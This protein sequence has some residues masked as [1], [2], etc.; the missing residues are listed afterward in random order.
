[1]KL[2]PWLLNRPHKVSLQTVLVCSFV[3]QIAVAV[4]LTGY[5]AYR[6]GQ[7]AVDDLA[8][9]LMQEV[10]DRIQ[11]HLYSLTKSSQDI[12][13]VVADDVEMG[14]LDLSLADL[15]PL[16]SY[17]LKRIK[18][19]DA[20]S[21]IYVGTE[22]GKFIGAGPDRSDEGDAY[23][24][25]VA[26]ETTHGNYVSYRVN[27]RG[28]RLQQ[29]QTTPQYDPRQ[30]PW[31]QAA[32]AKGNATWS[33]IYPFIGAANTGLTITAVKPFHN[34][35]GQVAGV[36]AVALYLN[37]LNDFLKRLSLTRT[38][39]V[40]ILEPSGLLVASSENQRPYVLR[41]GKPQRL[42]A[43]ASSDPL[44]R[45]TTQQ[46]SQRF[47]SAALSQHQ[48]FDFTWQG[49]RQYVQITPWRDEFGLDWQIVAV[50]PESDFMEQ[51]HQ[52]WRTSI[53][54]C[55][56]SLLVASVV[57]VQTAR[58]LTEPILR[59]NQAAKEV[60]KGNFDRV[61]QVDRADEVGELAQSFNDMAWQLKTSFSAYE[62][63]ETRFAKLLESLPVGVSAIDQQGKVIYINLEGVKLLGKGLVEDR[64]IEPRSQ[65]YGAHSFGA[66]LF[67]PN[68]LYPTVEF[69]AVRALQ[70]E[71][72]KINHL[73]IHKDTG[74]I[75]PIEVQST[76]VYDANGEIIYAISVFQDITNRKQAEQILA[77]YNWTLATQ[78]AVR[79]AELVA[80]NTALEQEVA[81]RERTQVALKQSETKLNDILNSATAAI[82][83]FRYQ[84]EAIYRSGQTVF[85]PHVDYTFCSAGHLAVFGYP[86]E[87]FMRDRTL[88]RSRIPD[89]DWEQVI[90]PGYQLLFGQGALVQGTLTIEYRFYDKDGS[91][92]WISDSLVARW[93]ESDRSWSITAVGTDIT[94]RK[95]AEEALQ[96]SE[97]NLRVVFN[98]SYDAMIIHR[99]DGT[100]LDVNDRM[101]ELYQVTRDEAMHLSF[102][103]DYSAPQ[104]PIDQLPKI[105]Q[106]VLSGETICHEWKAKRP[107]DGF[108]FDVEVALR[109]IRLAEQ[110]VILA[111]VR[112]I[113]DR[114][115]A[116]AALEAQRAFLY[117]V[118]DAVPNA[119]FVKDRLGRYTTINQAFAQRY[120][121]PVEVILGKRDQDFNPDPSQITQFSQ[122]NR[123]VMRS[124]QPYMTST[125][126]RDREGEIRWYQAVISPF[127]DAK[128]KVQGVI[129]AATDITS[130]KQIEAELRQ[131]KEEAEAANKAKSAFLANISHELR[132][133]L[134]AILGFSQLMAHDTLTFQQQKQ[135]AT[136]NRNGEHL[137][138]LINDVLSLAK[139]ESGHIGL[140]ETNCNLYQLLRAIEE[141]FSLRAANKGIQLICDRA[142]VP[143]YLYTDEQ[144]LRQ[145]LANLVDNAIKFT[146]QGSVTVRVR[147][148]QAGETHSSRRTADNPIAFLQLQVEDTGL[149][150]A[151]AD[152]ETIFESFKQSETGRRSHQGSGLGL[153]ICRHYVQ[154]L[155]GELTVSSQPRQGSCFQFAIPFKPG[156]PLQPNVRESFSAG[157]PSITGA[158]KPIAIPLAETGAEACS[159]LQAD[160]FAVMPPSWLD[161]LDFAA[162]SADAKAIFSLIEQIPAAQLDL[163]EA[164][165]ELVNHFQLEE[166]IRLVNEARQKGLNKQ[167]T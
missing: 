129:G 82:A 87:A 32:I 127:T 83:C 57:G 2:L 94:A 28:D 152:L 74:T 161:R 10:G 79:T 130:L 116:A 52:N 9:Q 164:I 18:T 144:K 165:A 106:W 7:Q 39:E 145:V 65:A 49:E 124:R 143:Q 62:Q 36:A 150:I 88:W 67:N 136:I 35:A 96:I 56:A 24:V 34:A 101:L 111:N 132:T 115:Q 21:F 1:M 100:I 162:R 27:E 80:T 93:E 4:G 22:T 108:I 112:D 63:S 99:A 84:S 154:L 147:A 157:Q 53:V 30:R 156:A 51:I 137:L 95:R 141:M 54:L 31:Y 128:G 138:Q 76:P 66:E 3:L 60:A 102:Q 90:E 134:N 91:L 38:G 123:K 69:P 105:W 70:D 61:V 118:I 23:L 148:I 85:S 107:T 14:A 42:A 59:L 121:L 158:T 160:V 47:S 45:A 73:E 26:D 117:Q 6:N 5:F 64:S 89:Q 167:E 13:Q 126:I 163:K 125:A 114:K 140:E 166:L 12:A 44:I 77:N 33:P 119:I 43:A 92:R 25:E 19:F 153:S 11:Q 72:L 55:I 151:A 113:S 78:V 15:Q 50:V 75:V 104:N 58:W 16:D 97:R 135:L 122:N 146:E 133:P 81:E 149:G 86:P 103:Q 29:I 71:T 139:I 40:F 155:G 142:T 46:F 17:F 68:S 20:A 8:N 41:D 131:A 110:D 120:G 48:Q 37:D 109:K 159:L 98:N